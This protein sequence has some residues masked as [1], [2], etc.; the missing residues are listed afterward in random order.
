MEDIESILMQ[1]R[2]MKYWQNNTTPIRE[3]LINPQFIEIRRNFK[4]AWHK[5]CDRRYAEKT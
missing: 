4:A 5:A 3:S 2:M 1:G